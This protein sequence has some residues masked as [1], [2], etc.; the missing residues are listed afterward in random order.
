MSTLKPARGVAGMA[1]RWRRRP[2]RP[3]PWTVAGLARQ[4]DPAEAG[5]LLAYHQ[6]RTG[7]PGYVPA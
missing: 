1:A 3:I 7:E 2:P 6:A 4:L 5:V